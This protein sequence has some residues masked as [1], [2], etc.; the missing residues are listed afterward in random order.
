[1]SDAVVWVIATDE[2]PVL[3]AECEVLLA[4]RSGGSDA[5]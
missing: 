5:D 3:R 4:Q 1:V 2:V